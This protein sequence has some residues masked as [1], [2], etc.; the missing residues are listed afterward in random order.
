MKLTQY[1]KDRAIFFIINIL[2]YLVLVFIAVSFKINFDLLILLFLIWFMPIFIYIILEFIKF[3]RYYTNLSSVCENLDKKYLLSEV[4]NEEQFI[5]A[6]LFNDI[7]K[8]TN[9][10]MR[11]EINS[12]KNIQQEYEEYIETWV[13]EIKTPIS[14]TMLI[15]ENNS[16]SIPYYMRSE[17][18]KIEDYVEQVLYYSKS[19]EVSKDYIVKEF[20][21]ESIVRKVIRKNSSDFI[22]KK[23]SIDINHIDN[24]VYSDSKWAEF[25]LNQIIS[26]SIKYSPQGSKI[27]IDSYKNDYN[28]VLTISDNGVGISNRDMGRIFEKG[29]TGENG[30]KF[31]KSTGMGLYICKKLCTKLNLGLN[32]DS[33]ENKGTTV[34]IIFPMHKLPLCNQVK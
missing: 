31:G 5:E 23:L 3:K 25:I 10:S 1:L 22:N 34:Q 32:I 20:N 8:D 28:I 24:I 17:V 18:Q 12:Y 2:L 6:K 9:K 11:E 19:N 27:S 30:R 21:L 7:L 29:F 16:E 15:I 26:N 4:I 14:S 33:I 13:H